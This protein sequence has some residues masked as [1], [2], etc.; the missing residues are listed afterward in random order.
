WSVTGVQTCA[1]P[2][3]HHR[4][5][6]PPDDG[7]LPV[8]QRRWRG[9]DGGGRGEQRRHL[10]PNVKPN[11]GARAEKQ[12]GWAAALLL[13]LAGCSAPGE[14]PTQLLAAARADLQ[15]GEL[16][17]AEATAEHG[18]ALS[19]NRPD[20]LFQWK[21]PLLRS[22]ILLNS[23]RAEVALA[24]LCDAMPQSPRFAPLAARKLMLQ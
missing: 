13:L 3:F 6:A 15:G 4:R 10:S 22:A 18:L 23:A 2:I 17:R 8:G 16:A 24:Q 7:A 20:L 1:L 21:P 12:K 19:A 14:N 5:I 11:P 9:S